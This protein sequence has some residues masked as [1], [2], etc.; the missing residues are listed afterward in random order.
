VVSITELYYWATGMEMNSGDRDQT[1]V[2]IA[3]GSLWHTASLLRECAGELTALRAEL[4]HTLAERKELE[5]ICATRNESIADLG[6]QNERLKACWAEALGN[7]SARNSM[8]ATLRD[9]L[10]ATSLARD[11]C[12]RQ[13]A[14]LL[15]RQEREP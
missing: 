10:T 2:S 6:Q 9:E 15:N 3:G 14:R 1:Q 13:C 12:E 8:I 11:A 5:A 4:E 7:V